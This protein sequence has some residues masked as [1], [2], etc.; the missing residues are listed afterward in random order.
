MITKKRFVQKNNNSSTNF[1]SKYYD[2]SENVTQEAASNNILIL[3]WKSVNHSI[4]YCESKNAYTSH[5]KKKAEIP[6]H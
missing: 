4:I 2:K 1:K 3:L 5:I 6:F